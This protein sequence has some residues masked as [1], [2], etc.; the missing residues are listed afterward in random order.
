METFEFEGKTTEDAVENACRELAIP[1]DDM[2]IEVIEAGSPGIFGLVGGKKAKVRISIAREEPL[3]S[4]DDDLLNTAR[5]TLEEILSLIPMED[6]EVK[7]ELVEGT[8]RLYIDGDKSGLLIGRKGRTLDALQFIVNKIVAKTLDRKIQVIIDSEDYRQRRKDYLVQMAADM[9]EKARK[10][11]KPI[12]TG[13][14]NPHDRRIVHI[15]LRDQRQLT[16]TSRGDGMLK[17]VVIIPNR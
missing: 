1:R 10:L 3:E 14:L 2:N 13:L 4:R 7:A 16:T 15:A 9:A 12:T 6:A 8:V 5:R 17:K 11:K